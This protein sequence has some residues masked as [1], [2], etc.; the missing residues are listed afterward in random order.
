[1][2]ENLNFVLKLSI[3]RCQIQKA[4]YA[5]KLLKQLLLLF[6]YFGFTSNWLK[7]LKE[8]I[9]MFD[10]CL[11]TLFIVLV[12]DY[13]H[14]Q[15]GSALRPPSARDNEQSRILRPTLAAHDQ[16]FIHTTHKR[17]IGF[18]TPPSGARLFG[19][20]PH[21]DFLHYIVVPDFL[22]QH[23]IGFFTPPSGARLFGAKDDDT[24]LDLSH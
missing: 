17:L 5:I 14:H 3:I 20:A 21:S 23:L 12:I 9:R 15:D 11:L 1:M 6:F 4:L 8:E 22:A 16:S 13:N 24:T 18:F 2:K 7:Y 10:A 19:P